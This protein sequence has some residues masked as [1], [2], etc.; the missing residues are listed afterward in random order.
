MAV[1]GLFAYYLSLFPYNLGLPTRSH[2]E[3]GSKPELPPVPVVGN[4]YRIGIALLIIG[5]YASCCADVALTGNLIK[6]D[7]EIAGRQLAGGPLLQACS[8]AMPMVV[9]Q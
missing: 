5:G 9:Q 2:S 3:L 6:G 7:V 1:E 4:R 8:K